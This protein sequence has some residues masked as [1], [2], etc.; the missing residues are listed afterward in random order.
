MQWNDW[1]FS[2][3]TTLSILD[4]VESK[5]LDFKLAGLL[6]LIMESRA[7]VLIASGPIFAGKTTLLHSLLDLLPPDLRQYFLRGFSEDFSF[8][9]SYKPE[10][11]YLVSE[12]ISNHQYDYLWG[13]Q[14]QKT[15][16]LL[17]QGYR[18]GTTTH[19]SNIKDVAYLL[20]NT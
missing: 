20:Y 19:A 12:E 5:T 14:V 9:N 17:A 18:L 13:H 6:W 2:R 15:F 8:I 10:T 1:A 4:L 3:P 11:A 7:S 16:R